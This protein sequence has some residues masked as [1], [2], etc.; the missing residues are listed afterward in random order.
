VPSTDSDGLIKEA[1]RVMTICNACR[2]CEGH[3]AVFPAMTLRINFTAGNL[4]YLANL[5]HNCGSCFHHC[6]YAPPHAFDVNVPRV[7]ADLRAETYQRY[8]WPAPLARLFRR[9]GLAAAIITA[10]SMVAL[11]VLTVVV[12]GPA[13][14]GGHGG[15]F[16][17]VLPHH[18]MV[19]LFGAV[20][21]YVAV[22]LA[23]GVIQFWRDVGAD[24]PVSIRIS[25]VVRAS[26]DVLR[27]RYLGG[28]GGDGCTYPTEV[29]SQV[30]RRF[31]HLTFYGFLLCLAATTIAAIY[32]QLGRM[33]PYPLWSIP[34]VLG[35]LGGVGLVTGP[36]GL[37]LLKQRSDPEPYRRSQF[38]MDIAFLV[39]LFAAAGT[40]FAVLCLRDTA[41]MAI[42]LAVHLGVVLGLFLTL[43]YGKFVHSLYR[44][45]ALVRYAGER[46]RP[47]PRLG[48][49]A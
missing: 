30:R 3:C 24:D 35:I 44:F 46:S 21:L 34:V 15:S 38:A 18:L 49:D 40:G 5:C 48:P 17:A 27:L 42:L 28:G 45:A 4:R 13:L 7:F 6:Q 47:P 41:A 14:R 32:H 1:E 9:N 20:G 16:Y 29:P 2:Y 8:A 10:I 39:L 37:L 12:A 25:T 19:G 33:A 31:H 36:I 11:V 22:A 23:I 26:G 43:P